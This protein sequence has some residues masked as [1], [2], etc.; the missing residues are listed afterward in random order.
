MRAGR[1][2]GD[3]PQ[4]LLG[5]FSSAVLD[6][7]PYS[8][9]LAKAVADYG[10][11]Q[12]AE[13]ALVGHS[14]GG[15]AIMNLAQDAEFCA[16]YTVTHVVA[17]GSPVDFKRPA[18]PRTWVASV[19][20]QHD[21][22]PTLDGQG[23]GNC[24]DLHPDWYVVD[25]FDST[26]LFPLCHSIEHYLR[27]PRRRP[28]RGPRAH[29]RA[30]RAVPRGRSYARRRTCCS[31]ARPALTDFPFLT[32]P[33]R[34]LAGPDGAVELPIRCRDGSAL[35]AYFAVDPAAARGLLEGTGRA[36]RSGRRSCP[37]RRARRLEPAHQRGRPPRTP[38]RHPRARPP[39]GRRAR[40]R[41]DPGPGRSAAAGGC[42]GAR[43]ASW[44]AP[45]STPPPRPRGA[46]WGGEPYLTGLEF[47]AHRVRSVT[48]AP[49]R[50]GFSVA[51]PARGR[52]AHERPR[53]VGYARRGRHHAALVCT[54]PRAAR[55]HPVPVLRLAVD[56]EL[57]PPAG[58]AAAR[59]GARRRPPAAVPDVHR[60]AV[61][62]RRRRPRLRPL[63]LGASPC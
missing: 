46:L 60:P 51:R 27:Q 13:L 28:A 47:R 25:Y 42:G 49:R 8:R 54:G 48:S 6:S 7:S 59:A 45:W 29:R 1:P 56:A 34:S 17:V 57:V 41:S 19:T 43:A 10:L 3:S 11:P 50:P 15:A 35:T 39:D 18:D 4:D 14:A 63:I 9:A 24:F 31:T 22:V 12:G 36:R 32:V 38:P 5:A 55:L 52:G 58:R 23:A 44:S 53:L 26:H 61:A 21:I 30:A 37:G 62:P 2:D 16:R 33:T 20:N 40:R